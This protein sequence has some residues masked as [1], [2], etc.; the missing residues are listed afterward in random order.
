M[1]SSDS[2]CCGANNGK[3]VVP[4]DPMDSGTIQRNR[5]HYTETFILNKSN[6]LFEIKGNITVSHINGSHIFDGDGH[7]NY[8][9]FVKMTMST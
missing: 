7:I 9:E 3:F 4:D 5:K 6:H 8:E 1:G 2:S